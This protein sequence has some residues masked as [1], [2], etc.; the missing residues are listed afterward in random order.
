MGI[1]GVRGW[2]S[3]A[4]EKWPGGLP[5]IT[6]TS[7]LIPLA[8]MFLKVVQVLY[9]RMNSSP[10]KTNST[11]EDRT[12]PSL[13]M[14]PSSTFMATQRALNYGRAG[15]GIYSKASYSKVSTQNDVEKGGDPSKT[16]ISALDDDSF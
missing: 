11:P 2:S 16:E 3:P 4:K 15:S 6:M 9:T 12:T 1:M 10:S 8:V 7:V 13:P 5:P 14:Y